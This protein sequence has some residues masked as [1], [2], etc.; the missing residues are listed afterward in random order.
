MRNF[1]IV[2]ACFEDVAELYLLEPEFNS[3]NLRMKGLCVCYK[4]DW[5]DGTM[6]K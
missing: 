1:Y 6:D 2:S 4:M 3:S 5:K